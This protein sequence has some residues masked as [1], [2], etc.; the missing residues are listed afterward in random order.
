MDT[1]KTG[2][3][4]PASK[5]K[6]ILIYKKKFYH[7]MLLQTDKMVVGTHYFEPINLKAKT[8]SDYHRAKKPVNESKVM[9][10]AL[11]YTDVVDHNI[12]ISRDK[13]V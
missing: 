7:F 8:R 11:E 1:A 6:E 12:K 4:H 13:I 9:G 10:I 5:M 2:L 3:R